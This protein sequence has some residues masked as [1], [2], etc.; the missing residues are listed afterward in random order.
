MCATAQGSLLILPE[1]V[2]LV[3]IGSGRRRS[4]DRPAYLLSDLPHRL[5][6]EDPLRFLPA[7]TPRMCPGR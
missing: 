5:V 2:G 3:G 7:G 6:L 1:G 4:G